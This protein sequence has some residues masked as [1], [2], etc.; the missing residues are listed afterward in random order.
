MQT[1]LSAAGHTGEPYLNSGRPDSRRRRMLFANG[2]IGLRE[3]LEAALA[4]SILI[5]FLVK[6]DRRYALKWVWVGVVTAL[7]LSVTAGA[8]ITFAGASMTFE[9]QEAF[10]GTMS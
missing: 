2:L 10:G 3:G 9:Q 4:V 8:V 5:A 6:T 7:V 1:A